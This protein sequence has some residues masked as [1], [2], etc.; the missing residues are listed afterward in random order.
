MLEFK[1]EYT[2]AIVYND[3]VEQSAI[4]QI[5]K[6]LNCPAFA[7]CKV[8]IM[9]DIHAGA[10]CVIGYTS[11]I[12]DKI[13]SNVV[14]VDQGC[15]VLI[16][17]IGQGKINFKELDDY[18]RRSVPIG[19]NVRN[20]NAY[21]HLVKHYGNYI[22]DF[23]NKYEDDMN[24][25][26]KKTD[27]SDSYVW[28]SLGSLGGGN[29]FCEVGQDL[30]NDVWVCIHSG[31]RN[32][33]LKVANY[34]QHKANESHPYGELSWL[35][36]DDK[37][38]YLHDA[39][40]AAEYAKLNRKL[41]MLMIVDGYFNLA[42]PYDEIESVHNY[43]DS[44]FIRKGAIEALDGQRVIVPWNMRDGAI[45]GQGRGN[46]EWNFSA[47]HGAGRTMGRG[48]AKKKLQLAKFEKEMEGIWSSC[49]SEKT[50]DESPMAYKDS[51][52]IE[53]YLTDTLT[54]INRIKPIYNLKAT[55][56]RKRRK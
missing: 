41:M 8:R 6:M 30:N 47:P 29:H 7:D 4:S 36:G 48:E 37:E 20:T 16:N 23:C 14:G 3:E 27:Q 5:Y 42:E 55:V 28:N 13:I 54:V 24:N 44:Q 52:L 46:S 1:G 35:E 10:G 11:T 15:G 17:N 43:V 49:I 31:S 26:I 9:S 25:I 53:K 56:S 22:D 12:N 39:K 32:F 45:V 51:N 50:L 21:N 38:E 34:H 33:G 2:S 19:Q 18:I 40:V